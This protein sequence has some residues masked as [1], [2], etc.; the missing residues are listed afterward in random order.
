M[1]LN[2]SVRWDGQRHSIP[3]FLVR[4][5][6]Y[7]RDPYF[8]HIIDWTQIVSGSEAPQSEPPNLFGFTSPSISASPCIDTDTG[9]H[10]IHHL[11]DHTNP[12]R[13]AHRL[14]DIHNLI[15]LAQG[16]TSNTIKYIPQVRGFDTCLN[17]VTLGKVMNV[18]YLFGMTDN[19]SVQWDPQ[20][21]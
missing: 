18:L 9:I 8:A 19:Q 15:S 13:P 14:T 1:W 11:L 17:K 16:S 12:S 7:K 3:Y 2:F 6:S 5:E 10:M 4:V 21:L 20:V